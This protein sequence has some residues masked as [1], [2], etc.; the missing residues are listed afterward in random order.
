[1]RLTSSAKTLAFSAAFS[2]LA[3]SRLVLTSNSLTVPPKEKT[4]LKASLSIKEQT[5]RST[6]EL[7]KSAARC[8]PVLVIIAALKGWEARQHKVIREGD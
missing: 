1:L 5:K 2:M 7:S 4:L 3:C 6:P 8:L